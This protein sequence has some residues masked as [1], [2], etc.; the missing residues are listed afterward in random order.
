MVLLRGGEWL[1]TGLVNMA[2]RRFVVQLQEAR[3][4]YIAINESYTRLSQGEKKHFYPKIVQFHEQ[5]DKA[6]R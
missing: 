4:T 1:L 6:P 3:G 5:L 2:T